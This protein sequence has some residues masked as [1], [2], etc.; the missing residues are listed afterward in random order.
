MHA[1][2]LFLAPGHLFNGRDDNQREVTL[3]QQKFKSDVKGEEE[4]TSL[5]SSYEFNLTHAM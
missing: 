1:C 2:H 3:D 5:S 4:D